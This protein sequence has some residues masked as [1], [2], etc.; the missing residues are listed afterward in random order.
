MLRD[1]WLN[2][3]GSIFDKR[4][5]LP[6]EVFLQLARSHLN[7]A[8]RTGLEDYLGYWRFLGVHLQ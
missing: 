1:R 5:M 6:G 3:I 7:A 2:H 4:G 8:L